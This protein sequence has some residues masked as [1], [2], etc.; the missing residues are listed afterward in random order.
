VARDRDE[1]N[2]AESEGEINMDMSEYLGSVFL[3]VNDIKLSGA[4]RVTITDV[5]RGQYDKPNIDFEDGTRLSCNTTNCRALARAYGRESKDWIG[6]QV[7]LTLGEVEYQGQLQESI[8]IKP[9][10]LR[11]ENKAP[12]K[13]DLD[14]E[15]PF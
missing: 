7:E 15:I 14:E 4:I 3:K 13:P 1:P 10:S 9:I 12:P 5:T 2:R 8:I 11:I 6:K